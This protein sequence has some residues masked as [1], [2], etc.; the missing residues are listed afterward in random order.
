MNDQLTK[1]AA[2]FIHVR[3][4]T[5]LGEFEKHFISPEVGVFLKFILD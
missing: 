4:P 5:S 2:I 1:K 3:A